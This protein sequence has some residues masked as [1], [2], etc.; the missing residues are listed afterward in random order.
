[1][2]LW[3]DIAELAFMSGTSALV[4]LGAV[5]AWYC[6]IRWVVDNRRVE[7][8]GKEAPDAK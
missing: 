7:R 4:V 1:M 5:V 8:K 2:E 3:F 6:F